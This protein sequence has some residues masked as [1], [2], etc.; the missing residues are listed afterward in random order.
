MTQQKLRLGNKVALITGASRGLGRAIALKFAE[1]G[2]A[3]AIN[4]EKNRPQA[5]EVLRHIRL[6]GGSA[7][8]IQADVAEE[9]QVQKMVETVVRE[10]GRIDILI[11]NAGVSRSFPTILD[12]PWTDLDR[13]L[14]VNYKGVL[15]CVRTA[16][17]HMIQRRY[18]K[19]VNLAS[20][21]ALGTSFPGTTGYAPTKAAVIT[22]TKRL[23]LE[24]GSFNI[25]VNAIAPGYIRT[26]MTLPDS[27]SPEAKKTAD[28]VVDKT[29][30]GR[31]GEPDDI[32][33]AALFLASDE[34]SFITSQVLTVDGAGLISFHTPHRVWRHTKQDKTFNPP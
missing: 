29:M 32:A 30:L 2:A 28:A 6:L 5:E 7:I 14:D 31:I 15:H 20:I 12:S 34:S 19:I 1:E 4:Y 13:M 33:H 9:G 23:A 21:A 27:A 18:G 22:L 10:F 11:N 26:D 3:I 8:L 17:R 25:T 16:A 24:L